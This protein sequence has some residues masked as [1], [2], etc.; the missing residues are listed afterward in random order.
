[1][2]QLNPVPCT[3]FI[4]GM[5]GNLPGYAGTQGN[6]F[7]PRVMP[8]QFNRDIL[9]DLAT[10]WVREI[11]RPES[12]PRRG[13]WLSGPK[14]CGKSTAVSQ[15]FARLGVPVIEMTGNKSSLVAD[16]VQTK[17]TAPSFRTL[18]DGTK[19][20]IGIT[21]R[22][23]DG[24]IA[25]AMRMGIPLVW[26]EMD[27]IDPG[28]GA[29]LNDIV[30]RGLYV[31]PDSGEV[32][33]AAR[34]FVVFAT[35]NSDGTGDVDGQYSGVN[36]MDSSLMRRFYK[37]VVDYMPEAEE[38]EAVKAALEWRLASLEAS[39]RAGIE[40]IIAQACKAATAI[41]AA[42]QNRNGGDGSLALPAAI[43]TSEVIDWVECMLMYSSLANRG[44]SVHLHALDRAFTN[45][46]PVEF[47]ETVRT[48]VGTVMTGA[49]S[50]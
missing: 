14:G 36:V 43:S 15:F 27:R 11:Q 38:I 48:L 9:T 10:V 30:D 34:G 41:R 31:V 44:V 26:N 49:A 50:P 3:D 6:P 19:E 25:I 1:M 46:L 12:A 42:Y 18:P 17:T 22:P 23:T 5:P 4:P 40:T 16:S 8:Y 37:I 29:G 35:A 45:S 28:E 13:A 33:R 39:A 24:P 47:R 20:P 21:I 7:L 32:I 2:F